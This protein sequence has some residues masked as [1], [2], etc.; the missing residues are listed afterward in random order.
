RALTDYASSLGPLGSVK[1]LFRTFQEERA[2]MLECAYRGVF[3]RK[4]VSIS[5]LQLPDGRFE[6]FVLFAAPPFAGT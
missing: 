6:Q 3:E 5:T 1:G 2:G 4:F